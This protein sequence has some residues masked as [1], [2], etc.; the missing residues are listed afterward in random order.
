MNFCK[1]TQV[2]SCYQYSVQ[3][4]YLVG[5]TQYSPLAF[6]NSHINRKVNFQYQANSNV[7]Q[8]LDPVGRSE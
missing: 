2:A 5:L 6:L 4:D 3:I 7:S 8:E 1:V